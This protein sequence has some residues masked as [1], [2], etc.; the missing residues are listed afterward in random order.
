MTCTCSYD[1]GLTDVFFYK[2]PQTNQCNSRYCATTDLMPPPPPSPPNPP[3]SPFSPPERWRWQP[4]PPPPAYT[5]AADCPQSLDQVLVLDEWWRSV[6]NTY[7]SATNSYTPRCDRDTL[8]MGSSTDRFEA[9]WYRFDG[10]AGTHM[11]TTPQGDNRCGS[12]KTGWLRG[13]H[14]LLG[15]GRR[16]GQVCFEHGS[17]TCGESVNIHTCSCSY[18]GG[19]TTTYMYRLPWTTSC[20]G[21]YCATHN[22]TELE[23]QSNSTEPPP[24]PPPAPRPPP[25]APSIP[26]SAPPSP[27]PPLTATY[28]CHSSCPHPQYVHNLSEGWRN[29]N[30]GPGDRCDARSPAPMATDT[31]D[32]VHWYKFEG[33]AGNRMPTSP[34]QRGQCGSDKTGWL[35]SPMPALGDARRD[36]HVCFSDSVQPSSYNDCPFRIPVELCTCSAPDGTG[37]VF[38][39]KLPR[40]PRC[41]A[42]Y[43]GQS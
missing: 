20:N 10:V 19:V 38:M 33:P 22:I 34:T 2:F 5:C 12:T 32:T 23:P 37:A 14:A 11:P 28:L 40:P 43:C 35:A 3:P 25:A 7:D 17:S 24:P 9:R 41:D 26:P 27:V 15:A 29:V 16:D 6:T 1:Q 4:F 39:Y 36:G 13:G 42:V 18:N 31:L 21:V 8:T 30:S